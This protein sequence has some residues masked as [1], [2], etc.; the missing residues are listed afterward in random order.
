MHQHRHAF[1]MA[2]GIAITA[3]ATFPTTASAGDLVEHWMETSQEE[4]LAYWTNERLAA[5]PDKET[6]P[7]SRRGRILC[8]P[9]VTRGGAQDHTLWVSGGFPDTP[10]WQGRFVHRH[11]GRQ[12]WWRHPGDSVAL[13]CAAGRARCGPLEPTPSLRTVFREWHCPAGKVPNTA[14]RRTAGLDF[15]RTRHQFPADPHR[16]IRRRTG[17]PRWQPGHPLR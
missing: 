4:I 13:P 2:S 14:D 6:L 10:G 9:T 15:R 5:V 17:A 8:R 1:R 11:R 3:C 12:P 16:Y 7:S